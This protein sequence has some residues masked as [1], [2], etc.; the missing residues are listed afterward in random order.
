MTTWTEWSAWYA[1]LNGFGT[2]ADGAMLVEW[3]R[4]FDADGYGPADLHAAGQ[5]V[6]T[7]T[8]RPKFRSDHLGALLD[9]ARSARQK[10]LDAGRLADGG[11]EWDCADCDGSGW[12]TVPNP[13]RKPDARGTAAVYAV[14]CRCFL[15]QRLYAGLGGKG[16]SMERYEM[17]NPGWRD[18]LDQLQALDAAH[19][20]A[21][22]NARSVDRTAGPLRGQVRRVA[23]LVPRIKGPADG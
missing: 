1:T 16:V 15:G 10:S 4:L 19:R 3:A 17:R 18:V 14:T 23:D 12:V 6:A 20:Q 9:A 8:T 2:P 21:R 7:G 11:R 5:A 13:K 22:D